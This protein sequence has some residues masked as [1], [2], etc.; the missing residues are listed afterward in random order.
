M[1]PKFIYNT[2]KWPSSLFKIKKMQNKTHCDII[3]DLSDW[4]NLKGLRT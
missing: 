2:E 1:I 4:Q 3:S